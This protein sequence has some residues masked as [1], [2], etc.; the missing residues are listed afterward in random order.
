MTSVLA[1]LKFPPATFLE[2]WMKFFWSCNGSPLRHTS[3]NIRQS[4][5]TEWQ[6]A[7]YLA[8]KTEKELCP[9]PNGNGFFIIDQAYLK[10]RTLNGHHSTN[11]SYHFYVSPPSFLQL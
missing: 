3:A 6:I 2:L 10:P 5:F 11:L 7:M 1:T 9:S 8:M 4:V